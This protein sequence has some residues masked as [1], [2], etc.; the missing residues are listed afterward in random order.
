VKQPEN[1]A[2][3]IQAA[4]SLCQQSRFAEAESLLRQTIEKHPEHFQ[5]LHLLGCIA[6]QIGRPDVAVQFLR[7]ALRQNN[8]MAAVHCHLGHAQRALGCASDALESYSTAIRLGEPLMPSVIGRAMALLALGRNPEALADFDRALA[9]GADDAEVHTFRGTA[10]LGVRRFEEALRSCDSALAKRGDLAAAHVNRAIALHSLQRFDEALES[11]ERALELAPRFADAHACRGSALI[12][13]RRAEEALASANE[14]IEL[15]PS[16]PGAHNLR[17]LCLLDLERPDEAIRSCERALELR[18]TLADAHNTLG[19]ALSSQKSFDLANSSFDRA[20]ALQPDRLEP[21]FNKGVNLLLTGEFSPGW[22]LYERRPAA[23]TAAA[24]RAGGALWDGSA[25]IAGKTV[26][27]YA[28]QGLGDTLQFCRYAKL[29][30]GRGARVILSVQECLCNLL[31]DLGPDIQVIGSAQT[32]Q[33]YDFR[34]ALLS[35]PGAFGTRLDAIPSLVPYLRA[36]PVRVERWRERLGTEG[37]LVGIRWQGGTSRADVGRSFP[38]HHLECL[39]GIPGVRLIS[40]QRDAGREQLRSLAAH[41]HIED[42]GNRFEPDS[43]NTFLD[44]AAV[45]QCMELI[46]TSDTSVAH[47]AGALGRPTWL[48]LKH[49]PDWRWLLGR[50]DSPWYPTMRLFRQTKPKD[51]DGVFARIHAELVKR[52]VD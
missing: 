45:M 13:L 22:E 3:L 27:V 17:A 28:E 9:L 20:I 40:L 24:D 52:I 2:I 12:E 50:D 43:A 46:I 48:A 1:P 19:L 49:V 34:C 6:S 10:L 26:Y 4:V 37:R 7:R 51:W 8:R 23:N 38:L 15:R 31:R 5:A 36:D 30:T 21:F 16:D 47:L 14:A 41:C 42:V 29:L 32:P 39:A 44:T 25:E 33:A 18:A 11:S 35:L